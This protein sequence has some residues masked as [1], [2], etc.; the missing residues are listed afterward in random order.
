MVN[1]P[2]PLQNASG[3]P[4]IMG[5][6]TDTQ[7]KACCGVL[8]RALCWGVKSVRGRGSGWVG[9][10][11]RSASHRGLQCFPNGDLIARYLSLMLLCLPPA[12]YN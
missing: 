7:T 11:T 3:L 8:P 5:V 2:R 10:G 4:V 1:T 9:E 6:T 12:L